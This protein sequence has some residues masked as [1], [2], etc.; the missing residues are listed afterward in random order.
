MGIRKMASREYC[1]YCRLLDRLFD[2]NKT[3]LR[4][5][6]YLFLYGG[7]KNG[8]KNDVEVEAIGKKSWSHKKQLAGGFKHLLFSSLLGE[9][10]QFDYCNIFQMGWNHQLDRYY[11][12]LFVTEK[13][14]GK[15]HQG[16]CLKPQILFFKRSYDFST[17][18]SMNM[19]ANFGTQIC[20]MIFH[21]TH[22][23]LCV[24]RPGKKTYIYI[25]LD[26]CQMDGKGCH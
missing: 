12:F 4:K 11:I 9:M 3:A 6:R 14:R 20:D 8:E 17:P 26:R 15:H 18:K 23:K 2:D 22:G 21:S 19:F 7:G 10:I 5:S 1:R 24:T 16:R 25:Y 13:N